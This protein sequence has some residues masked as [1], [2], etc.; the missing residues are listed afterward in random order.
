[1]RI[2]VLCYEYPPLGGGGGR[3]AKSVAEE[4]ARRGHEVRVQT[5]GMRHLPP[6]EVIEGVEVFRRES[7]RR[8]EESCSVAEMALYLIT[9]FLP[10]LGHLRSWRPDVIHAHFAVPTGALALAAHILS[11]V[12]YVLTVQLGDVPGGV[13]EQTDKLFRWLNPF[14]TPIWKRAAAITVVSE[15][16]KRLAIEAYGLPVRRIPN[17]IALEATLPPLVPER[18]PIRLLSVGRFNP[19]KNYPFLIDALARVADLKNWRLTM[20]GDGAEMPAVKGRIAAHGLEDRIELLGWLGAGDVQ[21]QMDGSEVF[22]MPSLSEGL[23]VAAV[24]A[25]KSGLAILGSEI[26]G[27]TDLVDQG[28]NGFLVPVNDLDAYAGKLRL[29]L[30]NEPLL[31]QCRSASRTKVHEFDLKEIGAQYE[32]TLRAAALLRKKRALGV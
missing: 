24:E 9:S 8:R 20:I 18:Q 10:T 2:L 21:S 31:F 26:G 22:L 16:V 19:Q 27:L 15:F 25:L 13:P 6:R 30:T 29:L 14:I 17:G 28:G 32:E 1:M 23:S 7:F 12:P 5:A 3:A 11:G 4:L